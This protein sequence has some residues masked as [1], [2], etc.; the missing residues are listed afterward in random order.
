MSVEAG[1]VHLAPGVPQDWIGGDVKSRCHL[2][3][4]LL[5]FP[6]A[7]HFLSLH[8]TFLICIVGSVSVLQLSKS[9]QQGLDSA[10]RLT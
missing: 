1:Q 4:E 5:E 7:G 6:W 8:L 10:T 3:L 9:E 2:C